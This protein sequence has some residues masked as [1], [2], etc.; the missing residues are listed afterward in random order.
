MSIVIDLCV[1]GGGGWGCVGVCMGVCC[2][3]GCVCV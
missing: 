1:C 2:V 3:C